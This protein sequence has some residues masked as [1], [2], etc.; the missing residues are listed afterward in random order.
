MTFIKIN[1]LKTIFDLWKNYEIILEFPGPHFYFP[2]NNILH[3]Y[4]TFAQ[5]NEPAL[6]HYY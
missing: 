1:I 5:V 6:I 4:G 3:Y 2:I